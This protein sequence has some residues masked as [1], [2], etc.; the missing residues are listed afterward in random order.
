MNTVRSKNEWQEVYGNG[1]GVGA[2][3]RQV[4]IELLD[5]WVDTDGS[6]QPFRAYDKAEFDELTENVRQLGIITPLCVRPIGERFQILAGHN[7]CAAAKAAGLRTVPA[8]I[9]AVDDD[10]A[11]GILVNSNL[12]QRQKIRPSEKAKAYKLLM[13]ANRRK[14]GRQQKDTENLTQVVSD[15]RTR[16]DEIVG[17]EYGESR[18]QVRRY[19]RLNALI[20]ELLK[21]ADDQQLKFVA[22]VELSYLPKEAQK[23]VFNALESGMK[24]STAKAKKLHAAMPVT[25]AD[26]QALLK[27]KAKQP[28]V[29]IKIECETKEI[30]AALAADESFLRD[31]KAALRKLMKEHLG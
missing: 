16:T 20:P 4:P 29:T 5:P 3:L 12:R 18:E 15:S 14:A 13:D 19:I 28:T 26:V 6:M 22:A 8:L 2:Q 10:E 1:F 21:M 23:I 7:R 17:A 30:A 24:L 25:E 11:V 31:A 9:K 27:E